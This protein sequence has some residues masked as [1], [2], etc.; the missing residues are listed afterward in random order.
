MIFFLKKKILFD[1]STL[2]KFETIFFFYFKQKTQ[3][4]QDF[5]RHVDQIKDKKDKI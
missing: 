2:N 1:I 5:I 4:R 3:K